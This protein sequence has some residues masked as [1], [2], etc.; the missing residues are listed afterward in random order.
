[1][2]FADCR[3]SSPGERRCPDS[4]FATRQSDDHFRYLA[5]VA[6]IT[7]TRRAVIWKTSFPDHRHVLDKTGV[8]ARKSDLFLYQGWDNNVMALVVDIRRMVQYI[9][10]NVSV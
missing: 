2:D 5:L 4:D 3:E 1:L 8:T 9:P 10:E 7:T 6:E